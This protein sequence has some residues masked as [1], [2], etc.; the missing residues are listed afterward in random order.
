MRLSY[1]LEKL[2]EADLADNPLDQFQAWLGDAV[3]CSE[4]VEPNALVLSTIGPELTTRSVLMKGIDSR[5]MTFY[6]N[7]GS[8][9]AAA[10]A[11]NPRVALLFP[12]YPLHRQVAVTGTA[13][14]VSREEAAAYFAVRPHLSQL[15][16]MASDQSSPIDSRDVLENRMAQLQRD[17]PDGSEVP[18]PDD[19]GGYLVTVDSIEFWQGRLSRLHDRLRFEA[20]AASHDLGDPS[21]WRVQ[22]YAP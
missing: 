5:G 17:F 13:S 10:I 3:Q 12:W 9:K 16:A 20:T 6:T 18:L 22:R 15:G 11:H 14:K 7:Y 2:D 21:Q 1:D 19:W 4:I 8:R